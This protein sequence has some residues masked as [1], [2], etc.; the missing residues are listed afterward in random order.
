MVATDS[1]RVNFPPSCP[2]C[3]GNTDTFLKVVHTDRYAKSTFQASIPYCQ[4]CKRH[5]EAGLLSMLIGSRTIG[6]ISKKAAV[7][8][9]GTWEATEYA[10]RYKAHFFKI[11]RLEYA[12]NLQLLNRRALQPLVDQFTSRPGELEAAYHI[13]A[14]VLARCGAAEG[15]DFINKRIQ[16]VITSGATLEVAA[17]DAYRLALTDDPRGLPGVLSWRKHPNFYETE[18]VRTVLDEYIT[19][20]SHLA[21]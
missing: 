12:D 14:H 6:C 18:R 5:V 2:R 4:T 13:V 1:S 19:T 3:S 15:F 16:E 9:L 10:E 7:L 11:R 8:P 21:K 20:F 17:R